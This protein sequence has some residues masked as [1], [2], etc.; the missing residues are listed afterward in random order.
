MVELAILTS[1]TEQ[2]RISGQC[3]P[4]FLKIRVM[5]IDRAISERSVERL[6]LAPVRFLNGLRASLMHNL[7]FS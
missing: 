1:A 4:Q 6:R 2:P 3:D 7:K 5:D